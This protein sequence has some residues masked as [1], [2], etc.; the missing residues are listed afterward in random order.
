MIVEGVKL[1]IKPS[2]DIAGLGACSLNLTPLFWNLEWI[3]SFSLLLGNI[4]ASYACIS[5][6]ASNA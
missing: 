1:F 3:D 5:V 6:S 2:Q 4:V